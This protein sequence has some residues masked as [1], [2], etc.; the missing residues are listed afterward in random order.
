MDALT[1][2]YWSLGVGFAVLILFLVIAIIYLIKI[3]RNVSKTT[4]VVTEVVN[5]VNDNVAKIT[6]KI[7]EVT[8]QIA[9]YVVKPISVIQFLMEKAK[10]VIEMIQ[11]KG[12]EWGNVIDEEEG[13]KPR[14]KRFGRKK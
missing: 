14:K 1:F 9:E 11:K 3:L 8:E 4:D 7:T 12:E 2:L 6:D 13:E 5:K 10:P